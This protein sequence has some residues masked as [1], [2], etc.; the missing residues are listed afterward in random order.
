MGLEA[1]LVAMPAVGE[2]VFAQRDLRQAV[3]GVG[4]ARLGGERA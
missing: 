1:P 3:L 2:A 4:A